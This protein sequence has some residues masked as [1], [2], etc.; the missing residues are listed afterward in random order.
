MRGAPLAA[1]FGAGGFLGSRLLAAIR[2]EHPAAPG[3]AR[4]PGPGLLPFRLGDTEVDSLALEGCRWAVLAAAATRLGQCEADPAGTRAVNV[5]ATLD[6]AARLSRRGI[7]VLWFSSDC[8]FDGLGGPYDDDAPTAPLN[9]YGRQK[10][11]VERRLAEATGGD[12][13]VVRLGKV[14]TLQKGD[15]SLLDEMAARLSAGSVV[16]AA[17]DQVFC[18][19]L[20]SDVVQ[21]V[22]AL[23][24][25][26]ARG[27]ANLCAPE[28]ASRL[29]MAQAIRRALGAAPE[30]VEDIS[31][32]DL[33]EAFAR[34][35]RT[36]MRCGALGRIGFTRFFP[37][38]DAIAAVVGNY[39]PN[40]EPQ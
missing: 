2:R 7:R 23:M 22:L 25:A 27:V 17:R 29:E 38:G 4:T 21:G 14:Y 30:L 13:L 34:P 16:R 10:A 31:L 3:F 15:G 28:A 37:L 26:E 36:P 32:D 11:E 19:T 18:P 35:K 9:E 24:Q 12:A 6:T 5:E 8:V 40:K 1:V 39:L 33:A 20:D